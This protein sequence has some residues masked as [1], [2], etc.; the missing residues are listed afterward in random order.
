MYTE[1]KKAVQVVTYVARAEVGPFTVLN[2]K[3]QKK[4]CGSRQ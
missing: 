4:T 1:Q 3:T 2:Q